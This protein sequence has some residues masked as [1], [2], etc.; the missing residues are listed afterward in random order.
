MGERHHP[1][2]RAQAVELLKTSGSSARGVA[3]DLGISHTVLLRWVRQAQVDRGERAG[4]TTEE[5]RELQRLRRENAIL[6]EERE[7]LKK[8][9]AFFAQEESRK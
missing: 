3:K 8:A 6:R 1:E 7:I 4:L 5:R 2:F 9:A